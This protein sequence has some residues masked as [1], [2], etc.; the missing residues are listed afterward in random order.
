MN[1]KA[2]FGYGCER[3]YEFASLW[4]FMEAFV[5]FVVIMTTVWVFLVNLC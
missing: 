5:R 3:V 4:V 2:M 1:L